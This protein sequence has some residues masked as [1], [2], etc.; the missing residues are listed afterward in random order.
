MNTNKDYCITHAFDCEH[1]P[2]KECWN[3]IEG[4]MSYE[5]CHT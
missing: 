5:L 1:C 3:E 4:G 2:N